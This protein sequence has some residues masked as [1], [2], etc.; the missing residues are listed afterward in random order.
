MIKPVWSGI[1]YCVVCGS[2]NLIRISGKDDLGIYECSACGSRLD[3]S[4]DIT[5]K[6]RIG[7]LKRGTGKAH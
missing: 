3:V 7:I 6:I 5:G 1:Q 4:K 2:K